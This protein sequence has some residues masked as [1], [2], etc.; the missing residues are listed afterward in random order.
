MCACRV[1]EV[2]TLGLGTQAFPVLRV[3]MRVKSL[4]VGDSAETR[5]R[6]GLKHHV[7]V[8]AG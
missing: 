2:L 1:T 5:G 7:R 6:P 3:H 8:D 4:C